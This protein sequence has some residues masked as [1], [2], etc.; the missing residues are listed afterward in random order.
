MGLP[1]TFP[2]L[3]R[4]GLSEE[5]VV[6]EKQGINL[7]LLDVCALFN[8][9]L[10][11]S[12]GSTEFVNVDGTFN[13]AKAMTVAA[14]AIDQRIKIDF[15][16]VLTS[17][18]SVEFELFIDG[19]ASAA[20]GYE[21]R[22]RQKKRE[23]ACDELKREFSRLERKE[24]AWFSQDQKTAI[25]KL[26]QKACMLT[27][28]H[29]IALKAALE[30]L[31]YSTKVC[32]SEADP[33]L[34]R[35]CLELKSSKDARKTAVVTIDSDLLAYTTIDFVL[36]PNIKGSGF[37]LYGKN[38]VCR[39]MGL[40]YTPLLALFAVCHRND[41]TRNIKGIGKVHSLEIIIEIQDN[42]EVEAGIKFPPDSSPANKS[43]KSKPKSART[44]P[45]AKAGPS[46][47]TQPAAGSTSSDGKRGRGIAKKTT[48]PLSTSSSD[49]AGS[50][51]SSPSSSLPVNLSMRELL[52][53]YCAKAGERTKRTISPIRF[54]QSL[55]TFL[56]LSELVVGE[57]PES[58]RDWIPLYEELDQDPAD[59]EE[60]EEDE[61]EDEEDDD[62]EEDESMG[63]NDGQ[64]DDDD[65][66]PI[67]LKWT[68]EELATV[69]QERLVTFARLMHSRGVIHIP[70]DPGA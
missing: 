40:R 12:A 7:F 54:E 16:D 31:G 42:I 21:H 65:P 23:D 26:L 10:M 51:S 18:K 19:G 43:T 46:S 9:I 57:T 2:W 61:E 32:H 56:F 35:R 1:G 22:K 59:V 28:D 36:R 50:T 52:R 5:P 39:A 49:L 20:K 3:H 58:H 41:Y 60:D 48:Q 11:Q 69:C 4:L 45:T 33:A 63:V 68:M 66:P 37:L 13:H 44:A 6:L 24:G 53:R 38:E 8:S 34:A 62:D 70:K 25:I 67:K 55:R 29:K 64:V 27:T 17:G 14:T 30:N 15:H 47:V